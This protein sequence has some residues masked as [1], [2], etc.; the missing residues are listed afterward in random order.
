MHHICLEVPD[1]LASL[2]QLQDHGVVLIDERAPARQNGT[3]Y[4]F[5]DPKSTGGVLLEL[6]QLP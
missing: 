1:I 4:A 2:A 6:Y 5:I 3:K